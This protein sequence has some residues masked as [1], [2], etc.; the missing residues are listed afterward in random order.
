MSRN[1]SYDSSDYSSDELDY[2]EGQYDFNGEILINRYALFHKLGSGS[3]STVWLAYDIEQND[4][5]AIKIQFSDDYYEA[6]DEIRFLKKINDKSASQQ[7]SN[8][9]E[10]L[11][12]FVVIRMKKKF[13]CMKFP[14]LA[15]SLYDL[16]RKGKYRNGL[17]L[18]IVKKIA[19]QMLN[20][21]QTIHSLGYIHSDIKP[22]NILFEGRSKK[23]KE[24]IDEFNKVNFNNIYKELKDKYVLDNTLD[25]NNNKHK[26]KLRSEKSNLYNATLQIVISRMN[27]DFS[28]DSSD[29]EDFTE[30]SNLSSWTDSI[31]DSVSQHSD[32]S[33]DS[34][35][36]TDSNYCNDDCKND[37]SEYDDY[38]SEKDQKSHDRY[39]ENFNDDIIDN[40]SIRISDFGNIV[41]MKTNEFKEIQTRYYRSPE[42]I[43]GCHYTETCDVW[44]IGCTLYEL[45]TG[46]LLFN[47]K[48]DKDISRDL[49]HLLDI[50]KYK[51]TFTKTMVSKASRKTEFFDKK[52]KLKK[53]NKINLSSLKDE[54][55]EKQDNKLSD[56]IDLLN[57]CLTVDFKKRPKC[58][59][60]L[61]HPFII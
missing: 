11:E 56:F 18:T 32:D 17:P 19:V 50:M 4:F 3:Y 20:G 2:E 48:K 29:S 1:S 16:I 57:K 52:L 55:K 26:K 14:I 34:N 31:D 7:S 42:V 15:G 33:S 36:S 61:S 8:I 47:P 38:D 43:I 44:S 10:L 60:L 27:L 49:Q 24:L 51:G 45:Y 9:N 41:K 21:F 53:S 39:D 30:Y 37:S 25:P 6:V 35:T 5:F 46:E 13:L 28:S 22:E 54:L 58:K 23:I 12:S 40:C 59:E